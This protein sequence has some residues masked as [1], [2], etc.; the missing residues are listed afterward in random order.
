MEA[1]TVNECDIDIAI[2]A[3]VPVS[4]KGVD[5]HKN[6]SV[7]WKNVGGLDMAKQL[8]TEIL[9]WPSKV[10][11]LLILYEHRFFEV[12]NFITEIHFVS[13]SQSIQTVS[14]EDAI[15]SIIIW[16]PRLW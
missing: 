6:S 3:I 12:C 1:V 8:L 5:F 10:C 11:T 15:R 13:V 7:T 4:L 14:I 2:S 9:I 16:C